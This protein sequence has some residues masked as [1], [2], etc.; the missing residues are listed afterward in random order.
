MERS[1]QHGRHGLAL[2]AGAPAESPKVILYVGGL[3]RMEAHFRQVANTVPADFIHHTGRIR[4]GHIVL[5]RMIERATLVVFP[6]DCVSHEATWT[7]KKLCRKANKPFVPLRSSG[8]SSFA[9][10][11]RQLESTGSVSRGRQNQA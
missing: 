10:A 6:V 11:M 1:R 8:L 2:D 3:E 4:G 7:V 5:E 9:E